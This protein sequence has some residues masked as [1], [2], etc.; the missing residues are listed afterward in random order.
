MLFTCVSTKTV[1]GTFPFC[2]SW[3]TAKLVDLTKSCKEIRSGEPIAPFP[4]RVAVLAKTTHQVSGFGY[5]CK[6]ER[7]V[8]TVH[9]GWDMTKHN[10]LSSEIIQL[11]AAECHAMIQS[12]MCQNQKMTC[13]GD[14]CSGR[15]EPEEDSSFFRDIRNVGHS[16]VF[17]KRAVSAVKQ[18][19][20]LFGQKCR[21]SDEYCQ[22]H[23]SII[24]WD[25]SI[26]HICPLVHTNITMLAQEVAPNIYIS[27]EQHLLFQ[28]RT[29]EII[30]DI[31][32][33]KT[34]DGLYLA[35]YYLDSNRRID[36]LPVSKP[37]EMFLPNIRISDGDFENYIVFQLY[38]KL[39][40]AI[41]SSFT[42]TLNLFADTHNDKYTV[43]DDVNGNPQIFYAYHE[44]TKYRIHAH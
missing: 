24:V 13:D 22:L 17:T 23:D 25:K 9:V 10:Y 27:K 12:K 16:C 33:R 31:R 19:D 32:V 41:C 34:T 43:I 36:A 28:T 5:Q 2:D 21:A 11:S 1:S 4:I 20:P 40:N 15:I 14:T 35:E 26:I 30:C 38:K 44:E 37:N 39:S 8:L 18:D 3:Q 29:L 42:A 6:E 7:L